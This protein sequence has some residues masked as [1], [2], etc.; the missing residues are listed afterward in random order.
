MTY[1]LVVDLSN[2]ENVVVVQNLVRRID[3]DGSQHT[4]GPNDVDSWNAYLVWVAQGN[5]AAVPA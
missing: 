2:R 1:Q 5:V 4:F 3:A